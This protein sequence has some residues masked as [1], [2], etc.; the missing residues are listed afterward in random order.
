MA[1]TVTRFANRSFYLYHESET[2]FRIESETDF[3]NRLGAYALNEKVQRRFTKKTARTQT[4]AF[5][6]EIPYIVVI[7]LSLV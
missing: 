3:A 4:H 6:F 1:A 7:R 2:D 5:G